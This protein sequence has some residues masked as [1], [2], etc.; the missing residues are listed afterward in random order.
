LKY[1]IRN[2]RFNKSPDSASGGAGEDE[3]RASITVSDLDGSD[4]ENRARKRQ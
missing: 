4:A 1:F 3:G 2:Q